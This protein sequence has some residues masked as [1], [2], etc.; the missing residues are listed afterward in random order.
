MFLSDVLGIGGP[1]FDEDDDNLFASN[2][3]EDLQKDPISQVDL[4]VR[5]HFHRN[6]CGYGADRGLQ[7]HITAFI[8]ES[9][10]RDAEGF[11]V[12]VGQLGA[13]EMIVL[14]RA[15]EQEQS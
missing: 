7:A 8:R 11:A 3:D 9:A 1:S 15:L 13:E 12:L 4:R 6:R 14:Q 2:D 5:F 10:G